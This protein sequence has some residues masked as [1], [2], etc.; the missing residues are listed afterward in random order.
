MPRWT[1][2]SRSSSRPTSRYLPRRDTGSTAA[3][4]AS[5]AGENLGWA[6]AHASPKRRPTTSGSSC[7]R[8]VSTSGSSGTWPRL[9]LHDD[10]HDHGPAPGRLVHELAGG[11]AHHLLQRLDVDGAGGE[12]LL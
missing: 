7:R 11:P 2:S 4:W 9:R 10:G 6:N 5:N 12:G 3:P 1:T 8:M